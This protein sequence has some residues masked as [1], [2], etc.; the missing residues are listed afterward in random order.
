M[1]TAG[2][3]DMDSFFSDRS[4]D[5]NDEKPSIGP[6]S[7]Q[8]PPRCGK[9][10]LLFQYAY[11]HAL[12]SPSSHVLFISPGQDR[13][14]G[15][16][17]TQIEALGSFRHQDE[18]SRSRYQSQNQNRNRSRSRIDPAVMKRIHHR[19][20]DS[21]FTL[22]CFLSSLTLLGSEPR[23]AEY[24]ACIVI[25]DLVEVFAPDELEADCVVRVFGLLNDTIQAIR[26]KSR[27]RCQAVVGFSIPGNSQ[28]AAIFHK[29]CRRYTR[30]EGAI[31][32]G[33]RCRTD[34]PL[35]AKLTAEPIERR[36]QPKPRRGPCSSHG[37]ADG[38]CI[39]LGDRSRQTQCLSAGVFAVAPLCQPR[40]R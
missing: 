39:G 2:L 19:Y 17:Q 35:P 13:L 15:L 37:R 14:S 6:V 1:S 36:F 30:W 5:D 29:A 21:A 10:A 11:A 23:L 38:C 8:G 32:P 16:F 33:K 27:N 40:E 3:V 26:Q 20:I 4:L 22:S 34:K 12:Q 31:E 28:V 25:D 9:T 7:I 24:P 18:G